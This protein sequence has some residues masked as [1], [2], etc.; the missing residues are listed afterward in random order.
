MWSLLNGFPCCSHDFNMLYLL[1]ANNRHVML[2][3]VKH[4]HLL[5]ISLGLII[6]GAVVY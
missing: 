5:K 2:P 4:R 1:A 6:S 3:L